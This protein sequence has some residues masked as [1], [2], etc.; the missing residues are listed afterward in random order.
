MIAIAP[1]CGGVGEDPTGS[2]GGDADMAT[3]GGGCCDGGGGGHGDMAMSHS[4]GDMTMMSTNPPDL[5]GTNLKPLCA[6]C[7]TDAECGSGSCL[8]YMMGQTKKCSHTCAAA[9]AGSDCPG[10]GA[11]NGMNDC[12]C[13][14]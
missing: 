8:P 4:G 14:N 2:G 10:I 1:G 11:C 6:T 12:K 3:A 13:P 9:T 5:A 7:T